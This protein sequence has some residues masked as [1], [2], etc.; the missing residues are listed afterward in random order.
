MLPGQSSPQ[1]LPLPLLCQLYLQLEFQIWRC[2][3]RPS[4]P[5][6]VLSTAWSALPPWEACTLVQARLL[7][8]GPETA[9]SLMPITPRAPH[10]CLYQ[11][12]LTSP[13]KPL[14]TPFNSHHLPGCLPPA[15][16][17]TGLPTS[18]QPCLCT[19]LNSV[20]FAEAN[21]FFS[22]KNLCGFTLLSEWGPKPYCDPLGRMWPHPAC[23]PASP[24]S[25]LVPAL[26]TSAL[27]G[28]S[29]HCPHVPGSLLP[30]GLCTCCPHCWVYLLFPLSLVPFRDAG[31]SVGGTAHYFHSA[32]RTIVGW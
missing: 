24:H 20:L 29:L 6:A 22:L 9:A 16:M 7:I 5:A 26:H 4:T 13:L 19:L 21:C 2:E 27:H 32:H 10:L 3:R 30:Q 25:T 31:V 18:A 23:F 17:W 15:Y 1:S 12:S 8:G 14:L 11:I 28:P